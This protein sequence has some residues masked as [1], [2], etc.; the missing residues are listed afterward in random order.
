M[1]LG[2]DEQMRWPEQLPMLLQAYNNTEHSS[3][4]LTPFFVI[5]GILI[6]L[7]CHSRRPSAWIA[8]PSYSTRGRGTNTDIQTINLNLVQPCPYPCPDAILSH[9][10]REYIRGVGRVELDQGW[11]PFCV[12]HQNKI[13]VTFTILFTVSSLRITI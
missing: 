5:F 11:V 10:S 3:T 2:Q 12:Q 1:S 6:F 4:G 13:V 8:S 9:S 7:F